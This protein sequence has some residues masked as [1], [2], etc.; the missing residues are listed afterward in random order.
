MPTVETDRADI[1]RTRVVHDPHA[2][3]EAGQSRLRVDVF[4]LS[5]N[6]VTYAVFGDL[7]R[8]WEAFPALDSPDTWGRVPVWGFADVVESRS[9]A[10]AVGERLFGFL[11]MSDELV[12]TPGRSDDH[13]LSDV[14][15]HRAGLF[16]TYNRYVRSA[17]ELFTHPLIADDRYLQAL[18]TTDTPPTTAEDDTRKENQ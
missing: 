17:V 11:P 13:A 4:G 2:A 10:L 6:N 7:L 14:A 12:I 18:D 3:L 9:D 1:T 16:S 8:C 5:A 15:E